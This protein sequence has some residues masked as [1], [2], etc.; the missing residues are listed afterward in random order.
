MGR[1]R[2]GTPEEEEGMVKPKLDMITTISLGANYRLQLATQGLSIK[3][4]ARR[5][6]ISYSSAFH[7]VKDKT[8]WFLTPNWLKA[9]KL[10]GFTRRQIEDKI[11]ADRMKQDR[12]YSDR[13]RF[14]NAIGEAVNLFEK[15]YR[16][17]SP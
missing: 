7:T 12:F 1:I 8:P 11:H 9:G 10:L 6:R 14:Y 16:K 4:M 5:A 15:Q 13:E 2:A 3:E 17:G